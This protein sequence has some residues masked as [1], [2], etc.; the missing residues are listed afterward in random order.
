MITGAVTWAIMDR[1]ETPGP[2]CDRCNIRGTCPA[3][4]KMM[5]LPGEEDIQGLR[6]AEAAQK[7]LLALMVA[8]A[9]ERAQTE[10]RRTL[11]QRLAALTE[12]N[13]IDVHGLFTIPVDSGDLERY[14]Y[15]PTRVALEEAGLWRDEYG[16]IALRAFK[17]PIP[18]MP[19][20]IRGRLDRLKLT[21][22]KEPDVRATVSGF[23]HS[24]RVPLLRGVR[25]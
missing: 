25:L 11:T 16:A 9:A 1:P 14:P 3:Y 21:E 20:E 2:A 22:T 8:R 6:K 18:A 4:E 24:I 15:G 13:K 19:A 5:E 7:L 17:A 10:R 23:D 12:D